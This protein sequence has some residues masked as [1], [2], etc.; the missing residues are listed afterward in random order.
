MSDR[1]LAERRAGM[2]IKVAAIVAWTAFG[3]FLLAA[4]AEEESEVYA[5][6]NG[7]AI[8]AEAVERHLRMTR[9]AAQAAVQPEAMP[10]E[11]RAELD[12]RRRKEALEAVIRKH[13]LCELARQEYLG[14]ESTT[15]VLDE[16][17]E[18]EFRKFQEQVGSLVKARRMLAELG[19]TVKQYKQLQIDN[20]LANKLLWDNVFLHVQVSPAEVRSY[21]DAQR[22]EL[23]APRTIRYR[24]I[25]LPTVDGAEEAALRDE[26]Q[27]LLRNIRNG[28]DF[29][30][31]AD[32][33]SAD[34]DEHPGGLREVVVPDDLPDWMPP[35]VEGLEPGQVSDVRAVASGFSIAML[36]EVSPARQLTF[37]EA[38]AHIK[39]TLTR[40]KRVA[41]RDKYLE[42]LQEEAH[43]EY[44]P[45]ARELGLE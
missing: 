25:F 13:L 18:K 28:L 20:V 14:G 34:R 9:P 45:P 19:L 31:A 3:G 12:R 43:I 32:R 21:Y 6:V 44:L 7:H 5:R 4:P 29:A 27:D 17:A 23:T 15:Q 8:T 26:A 10:P 22:G 39:A 1:V 33:Y 16:F 2:K 24:Q 37:Q 41:A 35:A 11:M 40:E 38:Q 42:R 36:E 30:E